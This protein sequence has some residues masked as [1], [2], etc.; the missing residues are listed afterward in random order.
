MV[1]KHSAGRFLVAGGFNTLITY[2]IYLLLLKFFP[3]QAAYAI[4]FALGIVIAYCAN[5]LFVFDTHRGYKSALMLPLIYLGQYLLS[6]LVIH[7]WIELAG[8]SEKLAPLAAIA[9]TVPL[10]Y[11]FSKLAFV[12]K[13]W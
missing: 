6:A 11:L 4:T 1:L 7:V 2:L 13:I 8:G 5:R 9:I 10:T 3:Y 12:G